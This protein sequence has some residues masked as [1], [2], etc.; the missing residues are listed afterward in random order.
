MHGES[1]LAGIKFLDDIDKRVN[2]KYIVLHRHAEVLLIKLFIE[3]SVFDQF[4]L[5]D[6][7][8]RIDQEFFSRVLQTDALVRSIKKLDVQFF[9]QFTDR[10]R[11]RRL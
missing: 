3:I 1:I 8:L 7:F 9:F 6:R 5:A 2:R 10:R 4:I 11:K